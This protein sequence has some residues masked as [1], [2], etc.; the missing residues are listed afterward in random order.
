MEHNENVMFAMEG[1]EGCICDVPHR[2]W[3]K[4]S[5]AIYI[6]VRLNYVDT[7]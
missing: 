2:I 1:G 6:E 3:E 5:S 4:V 7:F